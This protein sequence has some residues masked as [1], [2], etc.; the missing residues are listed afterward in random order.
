MLPHDRPAVRSPRPG[1]AIAVSALGAFLCSLDS[2]LN[3]AF[4]AISADLGVSP[5]QIALVIVFYHVPIGVLTVIGGVLGDRFGHRRVFACG[6]WTSA[7]AFPLCGLAPDYG[8]LLAARVVQG[9][10]AG[11]VLGTAPALVT[12]A[13]ARSQRGLG[14]GMM[15]F[16]AGAALGI[17]PLSAGF[18]VEAF[19]WRSVFLFRVPLALIVGVI[20]ACV[21]RRS[22]ATPGPTRSGPAPTLLDLFRGGPSG[23]RPAPSLPRSLILGNVLAVL[24]NAASF[25]TYIFVPYYLIDVAR[26]PAGLAGAIFMAVP[27]STSLGGLSGGW[28]TR[29]IE[30][31]HLVVAGLA[32]ETAGLATIASLESTSH[33]ALMV[34][35]FVLTGFGLGC[36][37]VPNMTLVMA[38]LPD[39]NQGLAGGMISA[40]RT[41]G[42]LTTAF[43]SPWLFA[44]RQA[45]HQA[46]A[47]DPAAVFL[48]AFTD[49]FAACAILGACALA[50][51]VALA[52]S[53]RPL[54]R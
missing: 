19:G 32:L 5:R 14:L 21:T 52:R 26:Y 23:E 2:A 25:S 12:L 42:I 54:A 6:V 38:A 46:A 45:V 33:P 31:R 9:A 18:L 49:T 48:A 1:V 20:V 3:V 43:G 29:R 24:A 41:V 35:G 8:F 22:P 7:L 39:Q 47:A 51:S 36:F 15:N 10:G 50:L 27:L 53:T 44:A 28:L 13:L 4:P 40:M 34:A 16:A 30:P 37:Q 11:L 17:A